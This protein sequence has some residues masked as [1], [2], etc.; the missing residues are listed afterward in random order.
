[1]APTTPPPP[2]PP[3][4]PLPKPADVS[5]DKPLP[6]I[7]PSQ[8]KEP[9]DASP[10][11]TEEYGE[12][13]L[14]E[15]RNRIQV[16]EDQ[17]NQPPKGKFAQTMDNAG[18][19][20]FAAGT[21]ILEYKDMA[22]LGVGTVKKVLGDKSDPIL[23]NMIQLAEKLVDVGK[24]VPI[25][26]PAFV[27]LKI[28]IDIEQKAREVDEKCQDL[29]ERIN[30]MVSHMLVLERIDIMDVLQIVLERVQEVL[31][32]AASLIEAYRKQ[33]KIA[34]RLKISNTAN[35]EAMADRI[36]T[37]SSDLMMS[38]QIQQTG[39]LSVLKRAVPRDLVAEKFI[40]DNGGQDFI[41]SHP[42]LVKEFAEKM[43]LTMSDQVMEQMQSN[44]QE[45]MAQNQTQIETII[46]ESSS[47]G[48]ADM[49]K[50]IANKQREWE[51]ERKL[52]CV[53]CNKEYT[54]S[55]NN[56]EACGF[57]SAV[58]SHD[59]YHC[60]E[61][62]S[63]CQK[64]Y[65]QPEHHSKY[66]YSNFYLWAYGI[67]GYKDTVEYWANVKEIDLGVEGSAQ[68]VRIG[69]LLRWR[70][71]GE[72]VTTPLLVVNVGH[73][74]DDLM[75]YL[76]IF[77]VTSLEDERKQALKT[78]NT[79]IFRNEPDENTKAFSMAEWVLDQ[80]TQQLV[81]IK[82]TVKVTNSKK[83]TVCL[84]S[85]DPKAIKMA[86]G[87]SLEYLSKSEWQ[88]YK[89]D[90]P[91][92]F[93]KTIQLGPVLRETRLREPRTFK[94]RSSSSDLPIVLLP[95]SEMVANNNHMTANHDV[96]RFLGHWRGLNRAPLSSQNQA[97]L[98][99]A[100]A[101]YRLLGE[102]EYRPV[103]SFGLRGDV[104]FPLS[105]A[106]SQ[107][108]DIPFEFTVDKPKHVV[109]RR[110]L[111]INFAH[112]TIHH[113]LRVR[114]TFTD[115]DGETISLVQEYVHPVMGIQKRK[116]ED[117][118]YVYIDDIDLCQRTVVWVKKAGDD[119]H[120]LRVLGGLGFTKKVYEID[121]HRI[122]YK[123]EK[124]K[125]TQVDMELGESNLG[126]NWTI[127][128]LVDL[129]CRR[130][131]GFKILVYHGSMTPVRYAASLGYV[132]CPLYGEEQMETRPI[133]YAEETKIVPEVI[134]R[135]EVVVVEDDTIDDVTPAHTP[136]SEPTAAPAETLVPE[137]VS[138]SI[139]SVSD[140]TTAQ[141]A[142]DN[143]SAAANTTAP[144][145]VSTAAAGGL[146]QSSTVVAVVNK[147]LSD[148][149]EPKTT[150]VSSALA[151]ESQ[152]SEM[153]VLQAK[154]SALETRLAAYENQEANGALMKRL[155]A[156]EEALTKDPSP[157][158]SETCPCQK[159]DSVR[160]TVLEGRLE[161]MDQK[162]GSMETS[163]RQLDST[164]TRVAVSLEKIATLLSA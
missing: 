119:T 27:I 4:K 46:R 48:V 30:F 114:I 91:Y 156:L 131:Y 125:V 58:G 118:G 88:V 159:P 94:T 79:L 152:K 161:S 117:I 68:I 61:K 130:V 150:K 105:L 115:I 75:H 96:D 33:G 17:Q 41:N 35:F 103:K 151:G 123:A 139:A 51:A 107:A 49:I 42:E 56:S 44:M 5:Q 65:H 108:I 136:T 140:Q 9:A 101:E 14:N 78:G 111:A 137:P 164:T 100:K 141:S 71:W 132:A 89:P 127:W 128:A 21:T 158:P 15:I 92:E 10:E 147:T 120:F 60:C 110:N 93:P 81:G 8:E 47:S 144:S 148:A 38:L 31:K 6:V 142:I 134:F 57:H 73:I 122:V 112:L 162:L 160:L 16:V 85:I 23:G 86:P 52:I 50:T 12:A 25:I 74:Q 124:T 36:S 133:C 106:P 26:A 69:R 149:S 138:S 7:D 45:L 19:N 143:T 98:L 22:E 1:M 70:T 43:Q 76:E 87:K 67:L 116:E 20:A 54:V 135:P 129:N 13:S 62:T 145:V 113:P 83:P 63:P 97:I 28:I 59:R 32:E 24:V 95:S 126:I 104:K 154:L 155:L 11:Y 163:I 153:E 84:L 29:M 102:E 109:E 80:E 99:S 34:R 121:L 82:L 2:P 72:L 3:Q 66:P 18:N 53:Q 157:K 40:N 37:C 64:G 90:R 146:V 55:T 77:D 39:D